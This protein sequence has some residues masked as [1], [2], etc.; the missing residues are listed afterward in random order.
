[1]IISWCSRTRKSKYPTDT[2]RAQGAGPIPLLPLRR[3][4]KGRL[5]GMATYSTRGGEGIKGKNP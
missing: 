1:M 2:L 4:G 3:T 5:H